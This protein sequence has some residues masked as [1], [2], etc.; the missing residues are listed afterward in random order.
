MND[1]NKHKQVTGQMNRLTA[2]H[3]ANASVFLFFTSHCPSPDSS[4]YPFV[5]HEQ[6]IAVHSGKQLP[7]K[8]NVINLQL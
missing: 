3:T 5:R 8:N 7:I 4:G 1:R 2:D 6:K